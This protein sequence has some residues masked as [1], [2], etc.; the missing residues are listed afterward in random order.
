MNI[1]KVLQCAYSDARNPYRQLLYDA[2]FELEDVKPV[3]LRERLEETLR[4]L[5][6]AGVYITIEE[7]KGKKPVQRNRPFCWCPNRFPSFPL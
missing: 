7:Y 6:S 1:L 4:K 2:G 3:V 5:F